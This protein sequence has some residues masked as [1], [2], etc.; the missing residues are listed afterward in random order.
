MHTD[1]PD[2]DVASIE[3]TSTPGC[4]EV[5]QNPAEVPSAAE[6]AEHLRSLA[7]GTEDPRERKRLYG[8][9]GSVLSTESRR[10][11]AAR[12]PEL[13]RLVIDAGR[14]VPGLDL[15]A[16]RQAAPEAYQL[17]EAATQ[18]LVALAGGELSMVTRLKLDEACALSLAAQASGDGQQAT[19]A[20]LSGLAMEL[21]YRLARQTREQRE[22]RPQPLGPVIFT[23][24]EAAAEQPTATVALAEPAARPQP[25]PPPPQPEPSNEERNA[26]A[27]KRLWE[28]VQARRLLAD[29]GIIS[30][31]LPEAERQAALAKRAADEFEAELAYEMEV[32]R[33][34]HPEKYDPFYGSSNLGRK[35][36]G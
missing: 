10:L 30:K 8:L 22:A 23:P 16:R 5:P 31:Y 35:R 15:A 11:T 28:I 27:S 33:N 26:E 13:E 24:P 14:R 17:L 4:D 25:A 7:R 18:D 9:A 12:R 1:D 34:L 19:L 20:E 6:Q 21:C 36:Y 3:T 32:E 29:S 2:H